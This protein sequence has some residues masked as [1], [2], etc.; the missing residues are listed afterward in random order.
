VL[1]NPNLSDEPPPR[2]PFVAMVFL[3]LFAFGVP[4]L[5]PALNILNVLSFPLGYFMAAQGTL[6]AFV[7]IGLLSALWQD[8]RAAKDP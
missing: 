2:L 6:I 1:D 8:R 4:L 7:A 5:V 3:A